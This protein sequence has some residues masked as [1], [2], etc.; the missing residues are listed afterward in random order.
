MKTLSCSCLLISSLCL[1]TQAVSDVR[2]TV[3]PL[4]E[5]VSPEAN[6]SPLI[7]RIDGKEVAGPKIDLKFSTITGEVEKQIT[8]AARSVPKPYNSVPIDARIPFYRDNQ[9]IDV[10]ALMVDTNLLTERN[11]FQM[12]QSY[13]DRLTIS[14][15]FEQYAKARTIS[16][17]IIQNSPASAAW[18]PRSKARAIFSFL[19][20]TR[21]LAERR[22]V[23]IDALVD[24]SISW[25]QDQMRQAP[26]MV[27]NATHSE[28]P[29][30]EDVIRQIRAQ[31]ARRFEQ[32]YTR[33]IEL[34][35]QSPSYCPLLKSTQEKITALP[36]DTNR[37]IGIDQVKARV[38]TAHAQCT[39]ASLL[40]AR[41]G[42]SE[43]R[44]LV[45]VEAD[46]QAELLLRA[47]ASRSNDSLRQI[48]RSQHNDI[49]RLTRALGL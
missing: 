35:S 6:S 43:A 48:A 47:E 36:D 31:E 7:I 11:V 5:P 45:K 32:L 34:G 15:T 27:Q 14:E 49:R 44:L 4:S 3:T 29:V 42:N 23:Q 17:W 21:D 13:S 18:S 40:A 8:V 20:L 19:R 25:L 1:A 33:I 2:L 30:L 38:V 26:V 41:D 28:R 37:Y 16:D 24:D 10:A 46:K 9:T 22:N 39:Y 12:M